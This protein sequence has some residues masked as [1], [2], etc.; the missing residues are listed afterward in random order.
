[1]SSNSSSI[2]SNQKLNITL[3][4]PFDVV[5]QL[6]EELV[7]V[8][9]KVGKYNFDFRVLKIPTII[10]WDG[11]EVNGIEYLIQTEAPIIKYKNYTYLATLKKETVDSEDFFIHASTKAE[12]LDLSQYHNIEFHC[13]HCNT[14]RY[15]KTVHV[16]RNDDGHDLVVAASCAK[17]YFGIDIESR[18]NKIVQFFNLD[19]LKKSFKDYII[20]DEESVGGGGRNWTSKFQLCATDKKRFC[21]L[22]FGII[23]ANNGKYVSGSVVA[24][25]DK[26]STNLQALQ[27]YYHMDSNHDMQQATEMLKLANSK[28]YN[29]ED[30]YEYWQAKTDKST[31]THNVQVALKMIQPKMGMLT[32]AVWDYMRNKIFSNRKKF[33]DYK[34]NHVGSVKEK[35]SGTAEII[36]NV[37]GNGPFG[38]YQIVQMVDANENL[39]SW[40]YNG[41]NTLNYEIGTK[42]K[43]SATI[44]KHDVFHNQKITAIKRAN[45]EVI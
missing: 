2:S 24:D 26:L 40:F 39:Y 45:L 34:S 25:Y 20:D 15:R 19:I 28:N 7:K 10:N 4:V 18:L 36:N 9:K 16:F 30:I 31:F 29:F 1:M 17:T 42:V 12:N 27:L 37:R 14:H 3:T 35:I 41:T 32:F 11:Q 22:V 6:D 5:S 8:Q 23:L 43:F 38:A 44:K 13:D 33:L 21:G